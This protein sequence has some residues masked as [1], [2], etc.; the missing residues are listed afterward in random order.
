MQTLY[1]KKYVN[2]LTRD[3]ETYWIQRFS[4]GRVESDNI[5]KYMK[6]TEKKFE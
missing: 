2:R 3:K 5:Q 4:M 1:I 6:I